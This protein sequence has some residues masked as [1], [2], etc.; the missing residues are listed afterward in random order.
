[1]PLLSRIG[2][3]NENEA[4]GGETG[5][6][7]S[8]LAG[9]D[10]EGASVAGATGDEALFDVSVVSEDSACWMDPL[11]TSSDVDGSRGVLSGL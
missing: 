4:G 9:A 1:M 10:L 8:G 6:R 5:S 2:R 3:E 11:G 7:A